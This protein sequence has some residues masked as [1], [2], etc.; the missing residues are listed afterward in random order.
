VGIDNRRTGLSSLC[1]ALDG[2]VKKNAGVTCPGP[3]FSPGIGKKN[4]RS[5]KTE[6]PVEYQRQFSTGEFVFASKF[7][8]LKKGVHPGDAYF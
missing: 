5:E 7:D 4:V 3:D 6:I 8:D 2:G 1:V